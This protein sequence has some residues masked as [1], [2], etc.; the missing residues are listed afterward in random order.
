MVSFDY[1]VKS[2]KGEL[3]KLKT[4][5]FKENPWHHFIWKRLTLTV[6]FI[7]PSKDNDQNEALLQIHPNP[8]KH[9]G[10]FNDII[11]Y[12]FDSDQWFSP[13]ISSI[14][15]SL[16][17]KECDMN[18]VSPSTAHWPPK[19]CM[20]VHSIKGWTKR[21]SDLSTWSVHSLIHQNDHCSNIFFV[22]LKYEVLADI[23][24]L[25]V[26]LNRTFSKLNDN[27]SNKSSDWTILIY[28][29][30]D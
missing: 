16:F 1:G 6:Q 25:N 15:N 30:S 29:P 21:S 22:F 20:R 27:E 23:C 4:I 24:L 12:V 17:N 13:L 9:N 5:F 14:S 8:P 28:V 19:I 7:K 3:W 26:F 18:E 11:S 2:I 10:N